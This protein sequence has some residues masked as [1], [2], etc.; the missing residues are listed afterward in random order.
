MNI[1]KLTEAEAKE[2][3]TWQYEELYSL[4]SFSGSE[5]TIEELLDGTYYG[6]CNEH[7]ELIGYF[8]FGEN[9]QVPGGRNAKLYVG[10]D[11]VDI[12]LGMKP[13]LTGRGLGKAFL[14]AGI[15]LAE[16]QIQP[17]RLRLS[18]AGFN[19]RAIRLYQQVG[20]VAEKT[21]DDRGREFIL[22]TYSCRKKRN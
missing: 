10:E 9:A 1:H 18:V 16:E 21:F 2:I 15:N 20:F 3:N 4:Y 19:K 5:E 12:G 22:M 7:G 8:C 17:D 14:Q 6:C 11:T 13:E